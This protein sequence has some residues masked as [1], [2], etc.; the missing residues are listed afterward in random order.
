M[1]VT[2]GF[3]CAL[4]HHQSWKRISFHT[5]SHTHSMFYHVLCQSHILM[6]SLCCR[7]AEPVSYGK[8]SNDTDRWIA[9]YA[10]VFVR[11]VDCVGFLF[12]C[13]DSAQIHYFLD[14]T[15]GYA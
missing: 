13:S 9:F 10:V 8:S 5:H 2:D 14:M 4:H 3:H 1:Q 12:G 11:L 7:H 15:Q 6:N